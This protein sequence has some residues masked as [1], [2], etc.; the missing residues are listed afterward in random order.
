MITIDVELALPHYFG[1]S[2]V[3]TA[4]LIDLIQ[5][6]TGNRYLSVVQSD[7]RSALMAA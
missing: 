5:I 1:M 6:H 2:K 7:I 3:E 4:T